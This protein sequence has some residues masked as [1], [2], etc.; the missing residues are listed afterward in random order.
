M[1]WPAFL[2]FTTCALVSAGAGA[3]CVHMWY[4]PLKVVIVYITSLLLVILSVT[5]VNVFGMNPR[6]N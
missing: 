1:T 5:N 2:R 6:V 3:Q 4:Q